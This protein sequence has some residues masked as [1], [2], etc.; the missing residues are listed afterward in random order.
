MTADRVLITSGTSEG[1]RAR[2]QRARRR[3]RRSA[4]ADADLSALHGGAREDRRARGLL[5]HRSG[6][7]LAAG[8]RS[9]AAARHA[10]DA[11]ARRHRSEQPD[12]R[13]LS[14]GDAPRAD[15]ARRS[16]TACRSSPTRST[17]TSASTARC[18][19]SAASSP[20]RRSSRSRP[21]RRRIS[22]RAGAPAGWPS[23]DAERLDDVL[24]AI[25]KLADGRLC[26]PGP[27]QY[28]V[29]AALTGDRSHQRDVPRGAPARARR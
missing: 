21:C 13:R 3:G 27:M 1:H 4:G 23:A 12:R 16:R 8:P 24:A 28:A 7:R 6:E 14:G 29:A 22:R 17:A 25:K 18:R 9:P 20:T 19:C 2:A 10:G 5:P 26:S 11:R 15:R